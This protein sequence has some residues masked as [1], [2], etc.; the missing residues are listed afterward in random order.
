M[1]AG[2]EGNY[3]TRT[4]KLIIRTKKSHSRKAFKDFLEK[5]EDKLPPFSHKL[6]LSSSF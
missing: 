2:E 5:E 4:V 1:L 3:N 6:Q